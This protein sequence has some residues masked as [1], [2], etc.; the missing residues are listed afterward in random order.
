M[1]PLGEL[2]F[3]APMFRS[4]LASLTWSEANQPPGSPP[5]CPSYS[6][7]LSDSLP[8]KSSANVWCQPGMSPRGM[9]TPDA[10]GG[11]DDTEVSAELESL[12]VGTGTEAS[13]LATAAGAEDWL[14]TGRTMIL[15]ITPSTASTSRVVAMVPRVLPTERPAGSGSGSTGG[16]TDGSTRAPG[17]GAARPVGT[18]GGDSGVRGCI[19]NPREG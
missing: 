11:A 10:C 13:S 3:H 15:K 12:G 5:G 19:A 17:G 6:P 2:A 9:G 8:V 14:G 16:T 4:P 1:Y 7:H 18:G